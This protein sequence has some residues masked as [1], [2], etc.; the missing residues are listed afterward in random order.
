MSLAITSSRLTDIGHA[1]EVIPYRRKP[2]FAGDIRMKRRIS[3]E[4]SVAVRQAA[5][6]P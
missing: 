5:R 2:G 1:A 4:K 3:Q 6:G